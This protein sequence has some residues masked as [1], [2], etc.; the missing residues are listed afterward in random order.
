MLRHALRA[1]LPHVVQTWVEAFATDPYFRWIAPD[2]ASWQLFG[3]R[4]MGFVAD[5]CFER[6]HTYLADSVAIAWVPPDIAVASNDDFARARD[7]IATQAGDRRADEALAAIVSARTHGMAEPHWTL[8]YVGVRDRARGQGLGS[9]AVAP[10]LAVADS[11]GLP[12]GL[13]STNGRNLSFYERQGFRVVAEV[14][15]VDGAATLRPMERH[16]A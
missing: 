5:L 14:M 12:V 15:T 1:D 2:D 8:Q 4:W 3:T 11:D 10:M 16:Q 6:G 7:L 13:T 9:L